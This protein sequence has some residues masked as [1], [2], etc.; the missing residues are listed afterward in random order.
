MR[1]AYRWYLAV[2]VC[3]VVAWPLARLL[4][5]G[6]ADPAVLAWVQSPEAPAGVALAAFVVLAGAVH[7]G[8]ARGPVMARPLPLFLLAGGPRRR[9]VALRPVFLRATAAVTGAAAG[10]GLLAA[11]TFVSGGAWQIA[12]GA[13]AVLGAAF[14]GLLVAFSWLMGQASDERTRGLLA[15]ALLGC[16]A[17]SPFLLV[18]LRPGFFV[19]VLLMAAG[20][21]TLLCG[22]LLDALRGPV[23]ERQSLAWERGMLAAGGGDLTAGLANLGAVPRATRDYSATIR[24]PLWARI[25]HADAVGAARTRG[26]F[27]AGAVALVC[28]GLLAGLG[29]GLLGEW[30]LVMGGVAGALVYAGVGAFVGGLRFAAEAASAPPLLGVGDVR[31]LAAHALFPLLVAL[32]LCGLGLALAGAAPWG[33]WVV[34]APAVVG[35]AVSLV[36]GPMPPGLLLPVA[37]PL[38]DASGVRVFLWHAGIPFVVAGTG[39]ALA[40]AAPLVAVS[41]AGAVTALGMLWAARAARRRA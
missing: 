11:A 12:H 37:S 23:L 38:G 8:G 6:L 14:F 28:G 34:A 32:V 4:V 25:L 26:S 1:M 20:A 22:R 31:H 33:S 41:S 36:R 29:A 10:L 5:L 18:G 9:R 17:A 3:L 30:A 15:L 24:G 2:M 21:A 7:A 27:V 35:R 39:A 40:G 19:T 13:L 16:A